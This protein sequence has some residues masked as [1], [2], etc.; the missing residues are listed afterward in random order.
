MLGIQ[1]SA[2]CICLKCKAVYHLDTSPLILNTA[3]ERSYIEA[4]RSLVGDESH[5]SVSHHEGRK[6]LCRCFEELLATDGATVPQL[7]RVN[8]LDVLANFG[9][10]GE[11]KDG[12]GDVIGRRVIKE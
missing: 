4:K 2:R 1:S 12:R 7:T 5:G 11:L 9:G 6:R 3:S 10:H 8:V